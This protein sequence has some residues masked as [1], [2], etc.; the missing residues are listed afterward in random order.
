[1]YIRI[2]LLANRESRLKVYLTNVF[3]GKLYLRQLNYFPILIDQ[4]KCISK[5]YINNHRRF[6]F[7]FLFFQLINA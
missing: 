2:R 6:S 1:M 5:M 3:M 7:F 4:R